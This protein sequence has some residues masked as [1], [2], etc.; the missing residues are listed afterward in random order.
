[1]YADKIHDSM[2]KTKAENKKKKKR[3]KKKKW[4]LGR[5]KGNVYV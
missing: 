3:K 1:M 2:K 4:E 5:R